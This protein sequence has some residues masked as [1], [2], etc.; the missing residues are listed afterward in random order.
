MC[1]KIIVIYYQY[2]KILEI[3]DLFLNFLVS[4]MSSAVFYYV[5]KYLESC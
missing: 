2:D 1:M 4:L 5:Q 3:K